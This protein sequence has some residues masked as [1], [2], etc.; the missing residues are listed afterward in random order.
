MY[1]TALQASGKCKKDSRK[2]CCTKHDECKPNQICVNGICREKHC[3]TL[4]DCPECHFCCTTKDMCAG[5][6][7]GGHGICYRK[8]CCASDGDC[9]AM[10]KTCQNKVC[11]GGDDEQGGDVVTPA[12]AMSG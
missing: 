12:T 7:V 8:P 1:L 5:T 4:T 2:E 11:L 10:G 3:K 9:E 6:K